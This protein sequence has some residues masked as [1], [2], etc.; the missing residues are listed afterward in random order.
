MWLPS[1]GATILFAKI[2]MAAAYRLQF[3]LYC[4]I[5]YKISLKFNGVKFLYFQG[6]SG[7]SKTCLK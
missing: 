4:V 2:R 7:G 5:I 6:S 3:F 1:W